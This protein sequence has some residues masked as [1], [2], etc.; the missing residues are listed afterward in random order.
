MGRGGGRSKSLARRSP[1]PNGPGYS[2]GKRQH[3]SAWSAS[4]TCRR[5][6]GGGSSACAECWI[7]PW[8]SSAR[9]PPWVL[10]SS[11]AQRV[12]DAHSSSSG[13]SAG[14][15]STHS[16]C[17]ANSSCWS[18]MRGKGRGGGGG[19]GMRGVEAVEGSEV[20]R[21][22]GEAARRWARRCGGE[23]RWAASGGGR[24]WWGGDRGERLARSAWRGKAASA[25]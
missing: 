25:A 18:A 10:R 3:R 4:A 2:S 9:R 22:S 21:R 8:S 16:T 13:A 24:R 11:F 19:A 7:A 5:G 15:R 23:R 17:A 20:R 1:W 14:P 6:G 12:L